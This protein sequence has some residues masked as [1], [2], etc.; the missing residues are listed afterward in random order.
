MKHKWIIS[1]RGKKTKYYTCIRCQE[2][3]VSFSR[4]RVDKYNPKCTPTH[5]G[6][7]G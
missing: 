4:K 5:K 2:V 1:P 3:E 6:G 7:T